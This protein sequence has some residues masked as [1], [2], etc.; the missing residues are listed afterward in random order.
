MNE[1]RIHKGKYQSFKTKQSGSIYCH[2][3]HFVCLCVCVVGVGGVGQE[4]Q[5]W[6]G[7]GYL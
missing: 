1:M 2:T 4:G 7:G 6:G 5:W 3:T